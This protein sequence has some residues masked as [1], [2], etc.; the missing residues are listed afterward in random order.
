MKKKYNVD[1]RYNPKSTITGFVLFI[2]GVILYSLEYFVEYKTPLNQ[3][4]NGGF[5]CS[6]IMLLLAP[7]KWINILEEYVKSLFKKGI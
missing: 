1:P 2:V 3:Y 6:G 5:I 7:D 4:V